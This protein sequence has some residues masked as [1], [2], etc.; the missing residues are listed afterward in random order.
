[1]KGKMLGVTALALFVGAIST[2]ILWAAGVAAP[3][4]V[5]PTK[6]TLILSNDTVGTL[7]PCG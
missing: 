6:I 3:M 1:M 7:E 5:K 2:A 4:A